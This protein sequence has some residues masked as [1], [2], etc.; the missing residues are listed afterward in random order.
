MTAPLLR[1][2][3]SSPSDV[4]PERL[5]ASRVIERLAREFGNFF[6][7]RAELWEQEPLL[8][9]AHFQE[10]I[11]KP[12]EAGIVLVIV[13]SRLGTNLPASRFKGALSEEAVTGTE[14][15]FED[16]ARAFREQGHPDLLFYRKT[17]RIE[18]DLADA[19]L[20][21]KRSNEKKK[22]DGF[23]HKWFF[24]E[25]AE[26]K[27]AF[28]QFETTHEFEAVIEQHLRRLLQRRVDALGDAAE[29][30]LPARWQG[31][32]PFRG[33]EPFDVEHSGIFYGRGKAR[34]DLREA[35]SARAAQGSAFVLLLGMSGSGKSSLV[36]AALIADL[37]VPGI[38]ENVGLFR[39]GIM[40][41]SDAPADPALSFA[42]A[43]RANSALPELLTAGWPAERIAQALTGAPNELIDAIKLALRSAGR[44]VGLLDNADAKVLIVVDQLEELFTTAALR[45]EDRDRFIDGL[46]ALVVAGDVWV[47]AT[48]RSDMFHHLTTTPKLAQMAEGAG[49]YHLL[50]PQPVEISQMIREPATAAGLRFEVDPKTNIG[51]DE[52]LHEEMEDDPAALPLLEFTL[53]ELFRLRTPRGVL[54]YDAYQ[55][56]G[57]LVGALAKR[58]E[59]T[60][61]TLSP[62][63]QE[64]FPGIATSLAAPQKNANGFAARRARLTEFRDDAAEMAVVNAFVES[65]LFVTDVA[66]SGGSTVRVA[67]EAL[68][69]AWPRLKDI[70]ERNLTFLAA[71]DRLSTAADRWIAEGRADDVLLAEGRSL[72]EAK[73]LLNTRARDLDVTVREFIAASDTAAR[74]RHTR[75]LRITQMV[76]AGFAVIALLAGGAGW[77]AW[78][79]RIAAD[80]SRKTAVT[81]RDGAL[82]S[83]SFF[84][85]ALSIK[86]T[87]SGD[88][89][90]GALLARA[91]LPKSDAVGDR[92][93]VNEAVN[94]LS[95]ALVELGSQVGVIR[96]SG[97]VFGRFL[98]DGSIA[99]IGGKESL[100]LSRAPDGETVAQYG[101]ASPVNAWISEDSQRV[102]VQSGEQVDLFTRNGKAIRRIDLAVRRLTAV[103]VAVD[104]P[105]SELAAFYADGSSRFFALPSGKLVATAAAGPPVLLAR[106]ATE[107]KVLVWSEIGGRIMV[108][109]A[110]GKTQALTSVADGINPTSLRL[111]STGTWVAAG[112]RDGAV[113]LWNMSA[114]GKPQ[115]LGGAKG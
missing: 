107:A 13:W 40:R 39:Y 69:R 79:S 21:E 34:V 28:S 37:S 88:P 20:V 57:G 60:Y 84:L 65:R 64:A 72:A 80:S 104:G 74:R 56:L 111:T 59:D 78:Q 82:R 19:A 106:Y 38:V 10:Q 58:A 71:R 31:G 27:A 43:L 108:R 105:M 110:D 90:S 25:N 32:S 26:F 18:V 53:D 8:A 67:H 96:H 92:P 22:L 95:Y 93:V 112:G 91:A 6:T 99:T 113:R 61:A 97:P 83:E 7:I 52:A 101:E 30:A 36:R 46:Q 73:E 109:T 89:Y 17:A 48:M 103:T 68:F 77:L 114:P 41:P 62:D 102:A 87:K 98:D 54:T 23:L 9:T 100:R 42:R 70:L 63:A 50:P 1:I 55:K 81:E 15:E 94:A 33:L 47:V 86:S 14:W 75:T 4:N 11:P 35:L 29:A 76:A 49:Q 24:T 66:G 5:A 16:A 3:I 2:F 51:L 115:I 44:T 85:A 45:A 12:S